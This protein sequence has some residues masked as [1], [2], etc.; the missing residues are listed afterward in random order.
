MIIGNPTPSG[1]FVTTYTDITDA[2][3]AE[4]ALALSERRSKTIF[5]ANPVITSITTFEDGRYI[6]V[7][8][9]FLN[10]MGHS[11]DEVIGRKTPE[12][13]IWVNLKD[14]SN[15]IEAIQREGEVRQL[16]TR[17]R[18]KNGEIYP[19][20]YSGVKIEFEGEEHLLSMSN[21]SAF[22]TV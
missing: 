13:D 15:I 1:G 19:A 22:G 9:T 2:K 20:I 4:E 10:V 5:D 14:R 8:R 11:R 16:E 21:V 18:K 17:F 7:N 6:D 12:L 3:R